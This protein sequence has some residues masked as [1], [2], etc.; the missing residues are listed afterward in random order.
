MKNNQDILAGSYKIKKIDDGE[1][2]GNR[3]ESANIQDNDRTKGMVKEY[4]FAGMDKNLLKNCNLLILP[5]SQTCFEAAELEAMKNYVQEGGQMLVL[6]TEGSQNNKCNINIFLEHFGIVPNNDCVIRSH[7][8]KY[9]HPKECY[10]AD[11]Q[12]N[13]TINKNNFDFKLV[14][15]FGCSMN[16]MKP[17][18]ICFKSG[19]SSFPINSPLG[20]LYCNEKSGGKLVAIGSK[21]MFN[22]N[23]LNK[24]NNDLFSE[25][26]LEYLNDSENIN[27]SPDCDDLEITDGNIV[28]E[29]A[30]L[31]EKAKLC[32]TDVVSNSPSVN[33]AKLFE[34]S[35]HLIKN[36]GTVKLY[37]ELGVKHG[38][39]K[40]IPPKFEVPYPA[41][42]AAVFPPSF[43]GL[44]LPS[45]ELF[46]LDEAFRSVHL[47]LARL[48]NKFIILNNG[49][50]SKQN[51]EKYMA[52]YINYIY[53]P[54]EIINLDDCILSPPSEPSS[55]LEDNDAE[56][57]LQSFCKLPKLLTFHRG[58]VMDEIIAA[59][60]TINTDC[61][62]IQITMINTNGQHE[63]AEDFGGVF[64]DCLSEFW[65][66]FYERCTVSKIPIIRHDFDAKKWQSVAKIIF[67]GW[68]QQQYFPIDI[69][70]PFM[71][72]CIF[73]KF[74]V[75]LKE[76]FLQCIS[77]HE[78]S[79]L[80]L[81]LTDFEQVKTSF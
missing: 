58:H 74:S 61:G 44:P 79:T 39:L 28:P 67:V 20:A 9:F 12:I 18:V 48:T 8:Y 24:E 2:E 51:N 56:S 11:S 62:P 23:Y 42:Q 36:L 41:L 50:E 60:S 81:A 71:E 17:S 46:D 22:D 4:G 57:E 47:K 77:D 16:I 35:F 14:Y 76:S 1:A 68:K 78:R 55:N 10:I 27:L 75:E 80:N 49:S 59:F 32:L 73:G 33:F 19:V 29:T 53:N 30:E 31:A 64:G 38:P 69:P 70:K 63:F 13:A 25:M 34:H 40:M 26:L 7:Y 45:L 15:P 5:T 54:I 66:S 43:T 52:D 6:L 21:A 72:I 3:V 37:E 65:T